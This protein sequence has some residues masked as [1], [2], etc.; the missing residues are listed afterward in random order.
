[1]R[2]T[3]SESMSRTR[4]RTQVILG[5]SMHAETA[6]SSSFFPS[7]DTTARNS[8]Q[9]SRS[10][11]SGPPLSHTFDNEAI[12][13]SPEAP[14]PR[15]SPISTSDR[16][17]TVSVDARARSVSANSLPAESDA[18]NGLDER[19]SH[20]SLGACAMTGLSSA[21]S[22]DASRTSSSDSHCA[23][24]SG[25]RSRR[26]S[27]ACSFRSARS[28][29][30]SS[31]SDTSLL[32]VKNKPLSWRRRPMV[33]GSRTSR[34]D[35]RPKFSSCASSP[36]SGGS[37]SIRFAIRL[38]KV[39]EVS[40]PICRGTDCISLCARSSTRK[41]VA[42]FASSSTTFAGSVRRPHLCNLICRTAAMPCASYSA[43]LSSS[44]FIRSHPSTP[45]FQ[46]ADSII[47]LYNSSIYLSMSHRAGQSGLQQLA[48]HL[49]HAATTRRFRGRLQ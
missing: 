30:I 28:P 8:L 46:C 44:W 45:S 22:F 5:W 34:F 20:F 3:I 38:K 27:A 1:M 49:H 26:L 9:H 25:R 42:H 12:K 24:L 4:A 41:D 47:A 17:T 6:I 21:M 43:R 33:G 16:A 2:P 15:A 31:G 35:F 13:T 37:S 19:V 10:W 32:S 39:S 48:F 36:I 40:K 7:G 11:P 23:N 18:H 29:H 14:E